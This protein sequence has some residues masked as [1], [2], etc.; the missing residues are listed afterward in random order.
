MNDD[1]IKQVFFINDINDIPIKKTKLKKQN[2]KPIKKRTTKNNP[3]KEKII[4][5]PIKN[6][7]SFIITFDD[8]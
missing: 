8:I 5:E 1:N 2:D 3:K 7:I 6:I 4:I